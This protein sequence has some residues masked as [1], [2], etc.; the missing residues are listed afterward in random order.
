MN[1][2]VAIDATYPTSNSYICSSSHNSKLAPNKSDDFDGAIITFGPET[3]A[4]LDRFLLGDALLLRLRVLTTTVRSSC[5][6][7]VLRGDDWGLTY[8]QAANLSW[9]ILADIKN[10]KHVQFEVCTY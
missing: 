9:A 8:E 6:E 3:D 7:A 5:W 10:Q 1:M 4:I 2:H